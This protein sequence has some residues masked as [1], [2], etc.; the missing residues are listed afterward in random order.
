MRMIDYSNPHFEDLFTSHSHTN[1]SQPIINRGKY[2][3]KQ[4]YQIVTS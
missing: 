4:F 2:G 3:M 1:K